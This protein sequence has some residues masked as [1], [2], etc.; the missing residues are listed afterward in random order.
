MDET[1]RPGLQPRT[2]KIA[3]SELRV[4]RFRVLVIDGP[5]KGQA[6]LS[7]GDRCTIGSHEFYLGYAITRRKLLCLDAGHF[8]PTESIADKISSVLL[9]LPGQ[10][11]LRKSVQESTILSRI[12]EEFPPERLLE[13]LERVDPIGV[14]VGPPAIVP[15]RDLRAADAAPDERLAGARPRSF[16]RGTFSQL[17]PH[18]TSAWRELGWDRSA[19]G[20]SRS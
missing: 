17:T 18:R 5:D 6:Y 20:P 14:V 8:H 3:K 1:E 7:A 9:Y 2:S 16:R 11:E 15:P 10:S 4:R 19:A 13:T 12:N